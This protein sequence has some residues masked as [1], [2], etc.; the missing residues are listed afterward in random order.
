M[1]LHHLLY[2]LKQK[3]SYLKKFSIEHM[4]FIINKP[5]CLGCLF[6]GDI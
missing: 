6:Q 3:G 1:D 5:K 4:Y 2:N